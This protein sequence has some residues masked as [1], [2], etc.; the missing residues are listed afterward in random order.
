MGKDEGDV[1]IAKTPPTR[2]EPN[3]T[4]ARTRRP[5]PTRARRR[6]NPLSQSASNL[7]QEDY[8]DEPSRFYDNRCLYKKMVDHRK[9]GPR[10]LGEAN[11]K[12]MLESVTHDYAPSKR[13]LC[14][15]VETAFEP[16]QQSTAKSCKRS[17][18]FTLENL[19][20]ED[21]TTPFNENRSGYDTKSL[22]V[23]KRRRRKVTA[24][25]NLQSG[26]N[27]KDGSRDM[28]PE[29]LIDFAVQR[30]EY[31]EMSNGCAELGVNEST[32]NMK[33]HLKVKLAIRESWLQQERKLLRPR[34]ESFIAQMRRVQGDRRYLPWKGSVVDSVVG[35]FLTQNVD[36]SLSSSAFMSLAAKYPRRIVDKNKPPQKNFASSTSKALKGTQASS[37]V[38][39]DCVEWNKVR[40]VSVREI[41]KVIKERGMN[42][43]LAQRIKKCL[44][45]IAGERKGIDLEWLRT[46]ESDE[47]KFPKAN[48]IHEYLWPI[49]EDAFDHETMYELHYQLITFGKVFCTKKKPNCN[50]CPMRVECEHFKSESARNTLT[51]LQE[52][53]TSCSNSLVESKVDC[54]QT[55]ER[56][57]EDLVVD[58]SKAIGKKAI[59]KTQKAASVSA[60]GKRRTEHVV[61]ELPNSHPVLV[62]VCSFTR[63]LHLY[64]CINPEFTWNWRYCSKTAKDLIALEGADSY[65]CKSRKA[66][67]NNVSSLCKKTAKQD[68]EMVSGTLLVFADD[69]SSRSPI[70][71]PW[72]S[73]RNLTKK[74]LYCGTSLRNMMRGGS[75]EKIQQCFGEGMK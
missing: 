19:E 35:A 29:E 4:R 60:L 56:D 58:T 51:G 24:C 23:Y 66:E 49:L 18:D 53:R 27:K 55:C 62:R 26:V 8:W 12:R 2:A 68:R 71:V 11:I 25:C 69:E 21:Q 3:R 72:E 61:Y 32:S 17:L 1:W 63:L 14:M 34:V 48:S 67:L 20:V 15:D 75:T 43:K 74:T 37:A 39:L 44:D 57:I 45:R 16:I 70:N 7:R 47:A 65:E 36:D 64:L 33:D 46:A 73:I 59:G 40:S 41:S 52:K 42:N 50:A 38:N 22:Q 31:P 10:V 6:P 9:Y 30:A 54:E 28:Q 5:N 13:K